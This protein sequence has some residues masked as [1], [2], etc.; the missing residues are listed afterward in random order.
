MTNP[1][2]QQLEAKKSALKTALMLTT[3][4]FALIDAVTMPA[5][6][7]THQLWFKL[8]SVFQSAANIPPQNNVQA[9]SPEHPL[10]KLAHDMAAREDITIANIYMH[11]EDQGFKNAL[12][13]KHD[14]K[15]ISLVFKGNP[16]EEENGEAI[17]RGVI[18]HELGHMYADGHRD[19]EIFLPARTAAATYRDFGGQASAFAAI[20]IYET[21][22]MDMLATLP[23]THTTPN[24]EQIATTLLQVLPESPLLVGI[25]GTLFGLSVANAHLHRAFR[26]TIEFIADVRG[27]EVSNPHSMHAVQE[28][29]KE[30]NQHTLTGEGRNPLSSLISHWER[31]CARVGAM[32][33]PSLGD[34]HPTMESRIDMLNKAFPD[35][36]AG[37]VEQDMPAVFRSRRHAAAFNPEHP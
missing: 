37:K 7:L 10:A 22:V 2:L 12:V 17:A 30:K 1:V 26:H 15:N 34:T 3:S 29:F 11:D 23:E 33:F 4:P 8:K 31:A 19:H 25:A 36:A 28:F 32:A 20:K 6:R 21:E 13:Y 9:L 14:R 16:L 24:V 5:T 27:A 18:G 35:A